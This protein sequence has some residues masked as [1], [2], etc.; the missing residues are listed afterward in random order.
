MA[1]SF[2]ILT[3]F[4]DMCRQY[5]D[6]SILGRASEKGLIKVRTVD[7][8]NFAHDRH[9]TVDDTPYGGGDGMVMMAGPVLEALESL[10]QEPRGRVLL[11]SPRGRVFDQE[12]ACELAGESRLTLIC[13]RYEGID[14]R[15]GLIAEPE[16]VSL[17][18]FVLTGGELA[19]LCLVDA[20][21]RLIPGVLGGEDSAQ[22]D[23]FM[24]GLLEHPHYTRPAEYRGLSVPEVLLGGNH[25]AIARWRRKE[26]LR[27]TLIRRPE[28]LDGLELGKEDRALLDELRAEMDGAA[29]G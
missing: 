9:R 20:V 5:C 8:R 28:L 27:K 29:K 23:S 18:D 12:M 4:P 16:E 2:D 13:G 19:A 14:E 3:L 26:S 10:P 25:A 7:I 22:A 24:D 11:L 6:S 15:V 17:G 21:A 1:F